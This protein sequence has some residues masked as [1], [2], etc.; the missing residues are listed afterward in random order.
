MPQLDNG[1]SIAELFEHLRD[2]NASSITAL[3]QKNHGSDDL[4]EKASDDRPTKKQKKV[5]QSKQ[6]KAWAD[7]EQADK[8][9]SDKAAAAA[10]GTAVGAADK[11]TKNLSVLSST[12]R[13]VAV[14]EPVAG[15]A[16]PSP[17]A[18]PEIG[19]LCHSCSEREARSL[20]SSS[21]RHCEWLPRRGLLGVRQGRDKSG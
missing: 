11:S 9:K 5:Q 15:S 14:R 12:P 3:L 7:K 16:T 2:A 6:E 10:M 17:P 1:I 4:P 21:M 20:P 13:W 8:V 19:R 18:T